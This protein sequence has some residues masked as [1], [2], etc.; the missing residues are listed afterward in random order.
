MVE[1]N[2]VLNAVVCKANQL[3][4]ERHANSMVPIIRP[5]IALGMR[6]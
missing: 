1:S 4:K 2:K 6:I 5:P 3:G